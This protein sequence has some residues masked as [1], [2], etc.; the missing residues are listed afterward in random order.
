MSRILSQKD[1]RVQISKK[2]KELSAELFSEK[3]QKASRSFLDHFNWQAKTKVLRVGF[4][5]A[6]PSEFNLLEIEMEFRKRR[7]TVCFPRVV[8][9][10]GLDFFE[11]PTPDSP[12]FWKLGSYGVQ[13]PDPALTRV[14]PEALDL[15]FV[16][17]V[18]FGKAGQRIGRG[19]GY[20]DR[21]LPQASHAVR[22]SLCFDLQLTD[23]SFETN[24]WDCPVHWIFT[25]FQTIQ[26]APKITAQWGLK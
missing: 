8:A 4:Y 26:V 12:R 13:E 5:R 18:A 14:S 25:E 22:I 7:H 15:I 17:G 24:S 9:D 6:L 3:C 19:G 21:F 16:P 1:L 10:H 11:I 20:Y 23:E 2:R